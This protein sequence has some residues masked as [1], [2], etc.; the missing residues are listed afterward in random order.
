M[1]KIPG[2]ANLAVIK[3]I[4]KGMAGDKKY[5]VET[6]SGESLLLRVADTS[7]YSS[8]KSEFEIAKQIDSLGIPMSRP[9]DFGICEDKKVCIRFFHGSTVKK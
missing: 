3:T 6:P 8:K 1:I 5:Y 7:E 9:I 2:Y 4:N